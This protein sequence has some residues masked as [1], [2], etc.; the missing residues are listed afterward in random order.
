MRVASVNDKVLKTKK[1]NFR[2]ILLFI[3]QEG[4]SREGKTCEK[5][6]RQKTG[7]RNQ[8][9]ARERLLRN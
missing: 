2:E 9:T 7:G 3:G 1:I 4:R 8:E 6:G 5:R